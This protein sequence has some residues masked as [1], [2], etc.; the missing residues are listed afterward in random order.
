MIVIYMNYFGE[1]ILISTTTSF[2]KKPGNYIRTGNHIKTIQ[3]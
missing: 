1:G 2:P 3:P